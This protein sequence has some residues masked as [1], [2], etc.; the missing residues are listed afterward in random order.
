MDDNYSSAILKRATFQDE[1]VNILN[2]TPLE[3][4]NEEWIIIS[5]YFKKRIAEITKKY[6]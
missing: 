1:L 5:N 4:Q 6:D 2:T 3:Y